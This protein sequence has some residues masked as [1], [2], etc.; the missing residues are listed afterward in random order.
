M[1]A[2]I[3][4]V[5]GEISRPKH[6][7]AIA[8]C[9]DTQKKE[10]DILILSGPAEQHGRYPFRTFHRIY[11]GDD[12][13]RSVVGGPPRNP[14]VENLLENLTGEMSRAQLQHAVGLKDSKSFRERYIAP[15][16]AAGL[17]EMTLPDKPNSPLQKYRLTEKGRHWLRVRDGK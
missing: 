11:A 1:D 7:F 17:V 6:S 10:F 14:Q 4:L 15:A 5:V 8:R 9:I 12:F 16:L 3:Q 2:K 13:Q